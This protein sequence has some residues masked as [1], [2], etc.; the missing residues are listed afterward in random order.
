MPD[1]AYGKIRRSVFVDKARMGITAHL[2]NC[3]RRKSSKEGA[4]MR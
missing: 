4:G 1:G 2:G 3:I